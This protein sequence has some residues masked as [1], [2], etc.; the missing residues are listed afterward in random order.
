MKAQKVGTITW[1]PADED[2]VQ[3]YT[4][5]EDVSRFEAELD[6]SDSYHDQSFEEM[7]M[8]K[9]A[10]FHDCCPDCANYIDAR[11]MRCSCKLWDRNID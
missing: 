5:S 7:I 6:D 2:D 8:G 3:L 11:T 10:E 4:N 1:E 9:Y